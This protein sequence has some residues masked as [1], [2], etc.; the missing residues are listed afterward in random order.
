M[1]LIKQLVYDP[2]TQIVVP[3]GTKV[4]VMCRLADGRYSVRTQDGV[5][6]TVTKKQLT[7]I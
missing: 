5:T 3:K 2:I 6:F 1:H 7:H 4:W